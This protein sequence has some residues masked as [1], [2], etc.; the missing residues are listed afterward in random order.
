MKVFKYS[1][2]SF[3]AISLLGIA[4]NSQFSYQSLSFDWYL[5][6]FINVLTVYLMM[7]NLIDHRPKYEIGRGCTNGSLVSRRSPPMV[8]QVGLNALFV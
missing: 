8:M 5:N 7:A 1:N 2:S 3:R 6:V 4:E